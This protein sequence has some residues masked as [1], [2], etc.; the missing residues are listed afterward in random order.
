MEL[1]KHDSRL[2]AAAITY[3]LA[4]SGSGEEGA[5]ALDRITRPKSRRAIADAT[6]LLAAAKEGMDG[7]EVVETSGDTFSANL[8]RLQAIGR[9]LLGAD[10]L[11]EK[12][13][14]EPAPPVSVME[15]ISSD[16]KVTGPKQYQLWLTHDEIH[17]IHHA[18]M[19]AESGLKGDG[20]GLAKA[21]IVYADLSETSL[22]R[23]VDKFNQVHEV[24][25]KDGEP[26]PEV[27]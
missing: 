3:V 18:V 24:A 1:S 27:N 4:I 12:V 20:V 15:P 23:F 5:D 9:G 14:A 26:A 10:K 22:D 16:G 8:D 11:N 21:A 7:S 17:L 25:R 13:I 2:I 6:S 19:F